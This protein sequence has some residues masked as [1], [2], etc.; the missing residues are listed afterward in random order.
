MISLRKLRIKNMS[1]DD[2]DFDEEVEVYLNKNGMTRRNRLIEDL[3]E[4]HTKTNKNGHKSVDSGYSVPTLNRK[5]KALI[6]SEKILSYGYEELEQ[7]GYQGMHKRA[8]YLLTPEGFKLK[9][10]IDSVLKLLETGDE[11]D[12]QMALKELTR[13]EKLYSFDESQLNLIIK[14]LTSVNAELTTKFLVTLKVNIINKGKEPKDKETL[15]K[16]LRTVLNKYSDP[17]GISGHVRNVAI[18]LLSHYKDEAIIDQLIKDATT[19]DNPFDVEEDYDPS[20]IAEVVINNPSRLF[21]TE[22]QLMKEGK[23]NSSQF[24]S[25]IRT[26]CMIQLGM[27]DVLLPNNNIGGAEF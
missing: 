14:N 2:I 26:K 17:K 19:L 9:I 20:S 18:C 12:Q 6:E 8:K 27:S 13:Y 3:T 24:I 10:H 4:K 25:N 15:L 21:E 1:K 5:L 22:R 11:I 16:A 23:H 7:Y